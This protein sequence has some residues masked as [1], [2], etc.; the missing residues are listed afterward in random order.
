MLST[1]H[2]DVWSQAPAEEAGSD[3]GTPEPKTG[4]PALPGPV[5]VDSS[6]RRARAVRRAGW[7]VGAACSV[8]TAA[9][10]LSVSGTTPIA[11]KTLLPLPGVPSTAPDDAGSAGTGELD[12]PAEQAA[13]PVTGDSREAGAVA[14]PTP[15]GSTGLAPSPR[16]SASPAQRPAEDGGAPD[17]PRAT[18]TAAATPAPTPTPTPTADATTPGPTP[19]GS[20]PA[21]PGGSPSPA[22]ES[23][24]APVD[25]QPQGGR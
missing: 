18:A 5:F 20:P 14:A 3:A 10:A 7:L 12:E 11:P 2:H 17:A 23:S 13:P 1:H 21:Q 24:D 16:P 8:Y 9:L 22:P 19:S 4:A 6:G 15:S 25:Q